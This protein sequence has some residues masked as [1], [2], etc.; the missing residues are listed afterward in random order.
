MILAMDPGKVPREEKM[1]QSGTDPE[2]YI[3]EYTL[4]YEHKWESPAPTPRQLGISEGTPTNSAATSAT[5]H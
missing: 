2:S 3:T 4:V 1:L 5:L